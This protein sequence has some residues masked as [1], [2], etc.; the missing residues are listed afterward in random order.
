MENTTDAEILERLIK[1]F[2]DQGAEKVY[3]AECCGRLYVGE[4]PAAGCR[5]CDNKPES[6]EVVIEREEK[7]D[8]EASAPG[9]G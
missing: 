3:V 4:T 8:G 6:R 2:R 5:T 9:E 1:P 7:K